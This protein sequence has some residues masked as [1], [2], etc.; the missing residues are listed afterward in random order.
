VVE[1]LDVSE[2]CA[3][4]GVAR[5][6]RLPMSGCGWVLLGEPPPDRFALR[7]HLVDAKFLGRRLG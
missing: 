6:A 1:A 2:S 4:D 7:H 3:T 5:H